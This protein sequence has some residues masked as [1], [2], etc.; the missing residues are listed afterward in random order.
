MMISILYL[1]VH[2]LEGLLNGRNHLS[3]KGKKGIFMNANT[4]KVH[5]GKKKFSISMKAR[6]KYV[7]TVCV[8]ILYTPVKSYVVKW[9]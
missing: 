5:E 1:K 7:S 4:E 2:A 6:F 3:M 8:L 9:P